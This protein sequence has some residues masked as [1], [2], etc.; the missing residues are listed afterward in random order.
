MLTE[1]IQSREEGVNLKEIDVEL[2]KQKSVQVCLILYKQKIYLDFHGLGT[3]R[4]C[5]RS[6]FYDH[7]LHDGNNYC[8]IEGISSDNREVQ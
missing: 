1:N 6:C 2:K 8:C 3:Q 4:K 7:H 5:S